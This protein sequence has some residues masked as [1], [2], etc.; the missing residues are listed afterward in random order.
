MNLSFLKPDTNLLLQISFWL[1]KLI[2]KGRL[3]ELWFVLLLVF[4]SFYLLKQYR[5]VSLLDLTV[6]LFP[7]KPQTTIILRAWRKEFLNDFQ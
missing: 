3:L 5:D 2:Q 4:L 6:E 7:L 1:G